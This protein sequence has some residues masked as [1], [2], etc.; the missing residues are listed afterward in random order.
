MSKNIIVI[1]GYNAIVS[2]DSEIEM[3]RG[4]FLGLN[5][6]ADFYATNLEALHQEGEISLSTFLDVCKEKGIEPVK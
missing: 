1:N 6:G 3:F 4:E 5:G 2:Y